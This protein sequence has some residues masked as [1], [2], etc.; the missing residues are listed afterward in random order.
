M[1]AKQL[2]YREDARTR[3]LVLTIDFMVAN[4]PKQAL[5]GESLL[6]AERDMF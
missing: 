6:G 5:A 1:T 2:L 3:S 4:A